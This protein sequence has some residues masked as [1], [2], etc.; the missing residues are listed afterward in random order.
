MDIIY[1]NQIQCKTNDIYW[2]TLIVCDIIEK[3]IYD[4]EIQNERNR[5]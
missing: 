4:K 2:N 1:E 5:I 3:E